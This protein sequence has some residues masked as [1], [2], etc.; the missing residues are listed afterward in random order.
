MS[1]MFYDNSIPESEKL[2]GTIKNN[3]HDKNDE[4]GMNDPV[5]ELINFKAFDIVLGILPEKNHMEFLEIVS[6]R[7]FDTELILGYVKEKT[8]KDIEDELKKGFENLF[9]DLDKEINLHDEVS[10]ET[11]V[12]IK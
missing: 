5:D 3:V 11:K 4:K 6:K 2:R 1:N 9:Q 7:P 12:P 8:G 10:T